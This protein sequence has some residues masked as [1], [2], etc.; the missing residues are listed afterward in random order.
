LTVLWYKAWRESRGRFLLSLLAIAALCTVSVV[1]EKDA[2]SAYE[3]PP[4][5]DAFIWQSVYKSG[6]RELFLLLAVL[7]GLGGLLRER[8]HGTASFTLAL[9]VGRRRLI[10]ARAGVGALEIAVLGFVP[11]LVIPALSPLLHESYPLSQALE[12]G[13]L[14]TVG[15]AV[16]FALGLLASTLFAGE[17]TAGL[18]SVVALLSYSLVVDVPG[19]EDYVGDL[20]DVMSGAGMPYFQPATSRL[21]GPLPWMPLATILIIAGALTAIAARVTERQDM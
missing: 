5:Y 11:A 1:F 6:V 8:A 16:C 15:G 20:H 13:L 19:V 21:T 9:P 3:R 14:W 12:F 18:C 4:T 17:Y 7:L 10:A 2:A